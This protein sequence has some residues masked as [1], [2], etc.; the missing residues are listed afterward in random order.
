MSITKSKTHRL[1]LSEGF[2]K[3]IISFLTRRQSSK[4]VKELKKFPIAQS[5]SINR[6]AKS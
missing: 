6:E 5:F 4:A 3:S 2:W 1:P